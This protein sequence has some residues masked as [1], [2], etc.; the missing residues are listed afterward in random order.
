MTPAETGKVLIKCAAF[1]QRTIGEGDINA[2]H[3]VIGHLPLAACLEAVTSHYHEH[4]HRAMPAD[5]RK[6]ATTALA[7]RRAVADRRQRRLEAAAAHAK[8]TGADMARYVFM[9]LRNAGQDV[10]RGRLLGKERCADIAEEAGREWLTNTAAARAELR[11]Y[12]DAA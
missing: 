4:S 11:R 2:W 3:E 5:I 6:L 7:D 12:L 8:V 10:P 9:A 1:D